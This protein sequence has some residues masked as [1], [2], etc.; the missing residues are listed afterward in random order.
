MLLIRQLLW[1]LKVR[2]DGICLYAVVT[3]LVLAYLRVRCESDMLEFSLSW[4]E[5][6]RLLNKRKESC[7]L[8]YG[9]LAG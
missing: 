2:I 7:N 5:S 6:I 8:K 4:D 9:V 3:D 1:E